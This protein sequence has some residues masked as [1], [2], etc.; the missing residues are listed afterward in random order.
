MQV[1]EIQISVPSDD[2]IVITMIQ[3]GSCQEEEKQLLLDS[4][5]T[6][7]IYMMKA[8]KSRKWLPLLLSDTGL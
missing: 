6:Y 4:Q 7:R 2:N 1:E 8:E 3:K 5:Q